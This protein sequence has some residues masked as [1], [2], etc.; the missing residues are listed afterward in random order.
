MFYVLN[1]LGLPA[2]YKLLILAFYKDVEA[3]SSGAGDGSFLFKVLCGVKTGC[4]LSA[5]LFLLSVFSCDVC[6]VCC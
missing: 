5:I 4:T 3:Y 1:C 2:S 6:V